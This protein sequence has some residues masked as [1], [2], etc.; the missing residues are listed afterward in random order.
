MANQAN[1]QRRFLRALCGESFKA[2]FQ[3]RG[4]E[5]R[6]VLR[7]ISISHFSCIF[8]GDVPEI[9]LHEKIREI[10]MNLRGILIKVDAVLC[11]KRVLG[12]DLIHVFVFRSDDDRE[13]MNPEHV[14]KVNSLVHA[15]LTERITTIIK[16]AFDEKRKSVRHSNK[17]R[18]N[19]APEQ[20]ISISQLPNTS[21]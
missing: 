3:Y 15:A 11:L 1:G 20:G 6:C 16:D 4:K 21:G 19:S 12:N 5:F 17:S 13:G 8:S 7:D 14:I 18:S 2:N 9:P 10:Q